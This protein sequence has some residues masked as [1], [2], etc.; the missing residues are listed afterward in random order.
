MSVWMSWA[1]RKGVMSGSSEVHDDAGEGQKAVVGS[2]SVAK[3]VRVCVL[4][5][6][7]EDDGGTQG[8]WK[9]LGTGSSQQRKNAAGL[10]AGVPEVSGLDAMV[11]QVA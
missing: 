4:Q 1:M 5:K 6:P 2:S 7:S 9:Q 8:Q 11:G 10:P 3:A